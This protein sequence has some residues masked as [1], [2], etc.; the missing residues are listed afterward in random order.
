MTGKDLFR[1]IGMIEEEYVAEAENYKRPVIHHAAFKR[2]LATAACLVVCLGIYWGVQVTRDNETMYAEDSAAQ[3][4]KTGYA[5]EEVPIESECLTTVTGT[6]ETV[7]TEATAEATEAVECFPDTTYLQLTGQQD[8]TTSGGEEATKQ[9][10]A[11]DTTISGAQYAVSETQ[12]VAESKLMEDGVRDFAAA[13]DRLA[14]Y[15]DEFE[16]LCQTE[17]YIILHGSV[18]KGQEK[19]EDFLTGVKAVEPAAIDIVQ[20]TIEGDPIITCL[21]FDGQEFYVVRDNTR[22]AFAGS[23]T[24]ITESRYPYLNIIRGEVYT[25]VYLS[26]EAELTS[27]QLQS[28]EYE[29]YYLFQCNVE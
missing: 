11:L 22:D 18:E 3:A 25:E 12:N 7:H 16:E 27:E 21:Y 4:E 15:P 23:G 8:N 17:A 6:T 14:A 1:E 5:E 29:T 9:D 20:F 24:G 13:K 19:W 2:A 28:G 10:S 26:K